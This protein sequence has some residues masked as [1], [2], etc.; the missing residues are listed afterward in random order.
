MRKIEQRY[1][2][3]R[4]GTKEM[5]QCKKCK[6]KFKLDPN[7]SKEHQGLCPY[8]RVRYEMALF[9][10]QSGKSKKE[11]KKFLELTD[12]QI[13]EGMKRLA[14]ALRET[15]FSFSEIARAM[16]SLG[17]VFTYNG[18]KADRLMEERRGVEQLL[19]SESPS[20]DSKACFKRIR[21]IDK[22]LKELIMGGKVSNEK[23]L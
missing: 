12:E 6:K 4:K 18:V 17:K 22:E 5:K 2:G 14:K 7:A 8:C 19:H 21:E 13:D 15:M 11:A 20:A 1:L 9:T 10:I 23:G 3:K 16:R